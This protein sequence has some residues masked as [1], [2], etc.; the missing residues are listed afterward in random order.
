M[1]GN[2]DVDDSYR[3]MDLDQNRGCDFGWKDKEKKI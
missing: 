1:I 3:R 2:K